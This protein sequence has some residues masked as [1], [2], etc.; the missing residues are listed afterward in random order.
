MGPTHEVLNQVPPLRRATARCTSDAALV[1]GLRRLGDDTVVG[2][3]ER[4]GPAGRRPRGPALGDRGEQLPAGA[5]DPR[6]LRAPDRRG[7]VPSGVASADGALG[8]GGAA[9]GALDVDAARTRTCAA[10][11]AS[12]LI[13][14]AEAGH[15]CPISMT[16]AVVPALR[17]SPELAG[18]V[19]AGS[20]LDDVRLRAARSGDQVRAA[21]RDGDDREAGRVGRPGEHDPGRARR[22]RSD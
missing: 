21:R 14:Q 5:A 10:R 22:G 18:V 9:R 17:H 16:Y 7:R 2:S 6:S 19:R 20:W 4:A 15:G 12:I 13:S 8:G 11:R 3:L 1:E